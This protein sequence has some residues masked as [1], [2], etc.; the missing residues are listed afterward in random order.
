MNSLVPE[1]PTL[2]I[3][4]LFVQYCGISQ[5]AN[6]RVNISASRCPHPLGQ[7]AP[8]LGAAA[9][10]ASQGVVLQSLCLLRWVSWLRP[11]RSL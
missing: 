8:V 1:T 10:L 3:R 2:Q 5:S 7:A 4:S 11:F 9:D 6:A